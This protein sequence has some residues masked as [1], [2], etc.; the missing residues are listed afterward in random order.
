MDAA[1]EP[2]LA[3]GERVGEAASSSVTSA[4][5]AVGSAITVFSGNDAA[6]APEGW[7]MGLKKE[8]LVTGE[9]HVFASQRN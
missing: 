2:G 6:G 3:A 4:S 8:K 5:D 9:V 7:M 1:S